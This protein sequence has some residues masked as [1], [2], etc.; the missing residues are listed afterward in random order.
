MKTVTRDPFLPIGY[1]TETHTFQPLSSKTPEVK[2]IDGI[3][4]IQFLVG[5]RFHVSVFYPL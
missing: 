4:I 3:L 5:N 1:V 2:W